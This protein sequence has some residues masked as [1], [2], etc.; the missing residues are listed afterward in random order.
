MT[1]DHPGEEQRDGAGAT[2]LKLPWGDTFD[3]LY[4]IL[5]DPE[6]MT[7]AYLAAEN[8]VVRNQDGSPSE[9]IR[10]GMRGGIRLG[11]TALADHL[12]DLA[13]REM[14]SLKEKRR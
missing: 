6:L 5:D 13:D 12:A 11:L 9:L 7:I 2:P 10:L 3:R 4:R 8:A 1:A 14:D